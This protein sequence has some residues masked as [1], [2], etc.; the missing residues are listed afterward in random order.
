MLVIF[1]LILGP[2][3][4]RSIFAS[5]TET[6]GKVTGRNMRTMKVSQKA[7]PSTEKLFPSPG[8]RMRWDSLATALSPKRALAWGAVATTWRTPMIN[9]RER[10]ISRSPV[11]QGVL[12]VHLKVGAPTLKVGAPTLKVGTPTLLS[13]ER[14]SWGAPP[15]PPTL[16]WRGVHLHLLI[17]DLLLEDISRC[18]VGEEVT[19]NL[20]LYSP[21]SNRA[22]FEKFNCPSATCMAGRGAVGV[23][24][25]V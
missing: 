6:K 18:T 3:T 10:R 15:P 12:D 11:F 14:P 19:D 2:L 5:F 20:F 23:A 4:T 17:D 25:G 24:V 21:G 16:G 13:L 1:L 8:G 22:T 7:L 9:C